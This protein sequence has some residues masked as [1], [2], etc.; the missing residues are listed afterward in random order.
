METITAPAAPLKSAPALTF[1]VPT[2]RWDDSVAASLSPAQL[3]LYRSNLLGSDLTVTNFGGG[4]TSA[5]LEE[6]DPLTGETV[7]VLWVKGSGGDIGSMK[8]DGFATLYQDKLLGLEQHYGGPDDDDKMVGYLPHCTFNLNGRAASIDTP[9][10]SLLPFAHV[11]HVHP[12]A[13][14]ALAASSGGEAATQAIWGGRIGWLAWKRPGYTLG[15]QLRDFVAANPGVE[16][17]MLAGHGIIC[18][19]D[20]AKAC[21]EHTVELIADAAAYLNAGLAGKPAF[22]GAAYET[23][24]DRAAIAADLMPRLRGLM[25]GARRKVGHYSDDAEALEFVNSA[26]FQRLADLGTSCPDH[27]LRTKIAPLTLDPARLHDDAYLAQKIADYR[28]LYAAYYERCKRPN[29]PAMRDAN[30]VV[31]LVPGI[32]RITFATDKTTARLAG[33]FYGNAINVM[34]GAE[35]IGDYIALDEQEAFDIE[36]WLLEEAKLQRMPAP[37]PLVGR[38]ALVTGG[39]GGIGAASAARLM[40]EGACVVLADR[41]GAVVEDVRAGFARQFGKD[42]VRSV[43]CDVTDEAQVAEAFAVAAREFG[44]LDILVANA[45]IA[46]SAPIEE[47]TIALWN[48]NYDVLAQGYFLT[49]R[50]AWPL[51]KAMKEQGGTSVVFI[52]S[53]NG[54]AAATNASAYASAKAA[55]NHLARCLALEGAPHGIRVNVVNPDA[56]IKGSRIWDGDWRKERAGA[57]GIDTGKELE[58]HYRQRSMLKR[59][60]LPGDI[61]EAVYFLA[62]DQSAKSTGNMIN[63]DAGNA[64][65]FTR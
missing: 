46:S 58:E 52:G 61:A 38:V 31:V 53:K 19:A 28:D 9:L 12:D 42:V 22:G 44:G 65:A 33:E 13:I 30:P 3:L 15:V 54:V 4:N 48:R 39:A 5:K 64:Q 14:I 57:H 29:S 16:G 50:A 47:T 41:D 20:S 10:H 25:T 34:R 8:L 24:G 59:D 43:V 35:A 45:G 56:V 63:V 62:G 37:K 2:S 11:D 23:A 1:A 17:V 7:E 18:W 27:F 40:A 55:A 36:Y 60:V 51:L 6:V 26:D 21:Y 32:G 49:S